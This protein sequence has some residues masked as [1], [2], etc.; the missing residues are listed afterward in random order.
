MVENI[1]KIK[2]GDLEFNLIQGGMGVGISMA[3]LAS[4]V[5][6]EG[7]AGIIASVGVGKLRGISGKYELANAQGLREEIRIARSKTK[8]GGVIGV[9]IMHALSDYSSLVEAAVAENADIIISGAGIPRDLPSYLRSDSKTKLIPIVSSAKLAGMM[10]KAW[11]KYDHLPDAIIVEGPKA[12]GHLGYSHEQLA[13][14]GFVSGGL[15]QIIPEVVQ[16]VKP[17]ETKNKIPVIA[18]GGIFY[19]GDI[20]KFIELGAAGVQMATRFVTTFEC[21]ADIKFKEAYLACKESDLR[22]IHSPVHMPGRAISNKFLE[23]VELGKK[24][25]ISC[26]Y[27]CLKTCIPHES[28]YCIAKAL[29]DAQKGIFNEGF[30]FCGYNA[31]LCREIVSVKQVFKDLDQEYLQ[32]KTS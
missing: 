13:D 25:P 17:Y 28:P 4:A 9:N 1:P 18:A 3:N 19:G 22:I 26:P 11:S 14:P 24:V 8:A 20:K 30:V 6:N 16:A 12:G 23:E 31:H 15:E 21:D 27:H 10:C 5:A 2:L 7:G 32:S 29:V